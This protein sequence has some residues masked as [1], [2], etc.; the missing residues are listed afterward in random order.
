M[1]TNDAL[2]KIF[3]NKAEARIDRLLTDMQ[4][5][6]EG[7]FQGTEQAIQAASRE[8]GRRCLEA[9]PEGKAKQ[10]GLATRREGS[11]GHQ[12]RLVSTDPDVTRSDRGSSSLLSM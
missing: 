4:E 8:F 7:D 2:K 11:C 5:G 1:E 9:L 12:Q 3:L 6:G 10:Q